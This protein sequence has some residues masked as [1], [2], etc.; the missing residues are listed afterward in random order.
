MQKRFLDWTYA[1]EP[2]RSAEAE[3]SELR[4]VPR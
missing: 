1:D 2:V 3:I 4:K